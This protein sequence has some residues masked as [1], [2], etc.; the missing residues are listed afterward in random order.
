MNWVSGAELTAAVSSAGGLGTLGPNAGAENITTDVELT[1]ERVR[2]QIRKVKSLT[3]KPFAINISVGFGERTKYSQKIVKVVIEEGVPVAI[4]SVGRPDVYT[5]TLKKAGMKVFHAISTARH[6]KTAERVGVDGVICEGFEAGGHKG[7]TEL[8][9]FVLI[10]IVAEAVQ[11]P[12]IAGGGIGDARGM[13]AAIALGA[14]GVYMGT[15]FMATKESESHPR[16]K[17]DIVKAE[18]VCTV[19]LPKDKM[20]ARD[21]SNDFTEKYLEMRQAGASPRELNDFLNEHSQFHGQ[22]LGQAEDAEVCCGQVAG[23]ITSIQGAGEI[24]ENIAGTIKFR[25]EELKEKIDD[26]LR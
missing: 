7:F 17:D 12:V 4:V 3:G 24:V 6:A 26:F 2:N 19:S 18:D 20:L 8:T 11:I 1:G 15:R 10:P 16:V 13:L 5:E 9:S 23:L 25:F 21:L 14:D 22:H